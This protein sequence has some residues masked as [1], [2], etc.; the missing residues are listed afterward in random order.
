MRTLTGEDVAGKHVIV[1]S[2]LNVPMAD[3]GGVPT[4]TDDGRIRASLDTISQ[5]S[6]AGAAV[7]VVAH[8]GRP[9]G[10]F[11]PGLSLR[12]VAV[13]MAELLDQPVEFVPDLVGG[14]ARS[15]SAALEPGQILVL[16]NVR[17]DPRETSKDPA[18]RMALAD[19]LAKFGDLYVSDGFGVVHRQQASV[20][21][22]AE[23]L[24]AVAG[25]L[26]AAESAVF[27]KV[28]DAPDHPYA[29][30]L[31]GAKVSDK[32][33]VISRLINSV[34]RLVIGGGMC[35]TFLAAKGYSVGDSLLEADQVETISVLLDQ[36]AA[37]GVE[38]VLPVDVVVADAFSAEA[39]SKTVP[40]DSIP[41]GWQG[42]DIG[43]ASVDLFVSRLA[44]CQTIVWNGPM[45]VFEMA[46][47]AA[48]TRAIAEAMAHSDGFTVVGGGDS[49]AAIRLLGIDEA[50]F[51]HISTGGGA[52]LEFLE[53]KQL[54]GIAVLEE[55]HDV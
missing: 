42:L 32:L 1:R 21:E 49:A 48:G 27:R 34:D 40:A 41:D 12:P 20:T 9:K 4:I 54:P 29:V 55:N 43:P 5:L 35:F 8:L 22:I 44:D 31:G 28:L 7:I 11:V 24:P 13:R 33:G 45:G 14:A 2:D 16:E 10:R 15:A 37:N 19:E 6:S 30:V 23:C 38:I 36:A 47:F 18:D 53:G 3:Q 25:N 46:P 26:V 50:R 51:S 39:D 52:S 17:F